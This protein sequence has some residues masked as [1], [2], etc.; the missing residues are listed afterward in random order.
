[1]ESQILI[2]QAEDGNTKIDVR[3]EGETVW[4]SQKFYKAYYQKED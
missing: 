4:L 2:N 1:M 3:L